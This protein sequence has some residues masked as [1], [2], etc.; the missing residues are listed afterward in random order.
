VFKQYGKLSGCFDIS[1]MSTQDNINEESS[2]DPFYAGIMTNK[3]AGKPFQK[4][5]AV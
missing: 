5:L 1:A 3:N 2:Q 4:Y